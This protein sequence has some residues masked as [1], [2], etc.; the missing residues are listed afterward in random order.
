MLQDK[1]ISKNY[2]LICIKHIRWF[3]A[4]A[5]IIVCAWL[6][7]SDLEGQANII[8]CPSKLLYQIPCPGCGITRATLKFFHL[9]IVD[10][11]ALNPNVIFS[12]LFIICS[13]FILLVDIVSKN[14]IVFRLYNNIEALLHQK[15]IWIPFFFFELFIW[16]RNVM[17]GI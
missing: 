7:Y 15:I 4:I 1:R 12:I 5:Y 9:N 3:L 16:I 6:V 11:L 13:P 14:N 17:Y 10:A 8:V 2:K